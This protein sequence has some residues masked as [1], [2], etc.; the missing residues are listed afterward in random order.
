MSTASE[1]DRRILAR[2]AELLAR[3]L[4]PATHGGDELEVVVCE[5]GA[6]R[7]GFPLQH[8]REIVPRPPLTPLP[9]VPP[10]MLGVGQVRGVL[11]GVIDLGRFLDVAGETRPDHVVVVDGPEGPIALAVDRVLACRLVPRA[12]LDAQ[13]DG[14]RR[15][16]L[17]VTADLVT[18]LDL[19]RLVARP[20]LRLE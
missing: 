3:R 8:L 20:D 13:G 17:G 12:G 6:E 11:L 10:W 15:A 9:F 4:A 2:R 18:V 1:R 16:A 19:P 14:D 5:V 7:F